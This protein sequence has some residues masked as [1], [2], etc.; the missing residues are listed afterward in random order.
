MPSNADLT[1]PARGALTHPTRP[2][3]RVRRGFSL[4]EISLVLIIM[5]ILMTV[6][7][8]SMTGRAD[9][10]KRTTTMAK[11]S[12]IKQA[13]DQYG[14]KYNSMPP[15]LA[16]LVQAGYITEVP[17]DDW[18]TQLYY[19]VPGLQGKPY[20]LISMGPTK[21]PGDPGNINVWTMNQK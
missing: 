4:L 15:T 21:Q 9:D 3:R 12:Q 11:M 7:V 5:G 8:V 19:M 1:L 2:A 13:L 6:V 20:D 18:G 10:A 17:T 14:L 16:N